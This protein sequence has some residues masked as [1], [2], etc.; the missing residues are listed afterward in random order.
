MRAITVD[1]SVFVSAARA[2][3]PSHADSLAF[4]DGLRESNNRLFLPTLALAEVAAAL[5]RTGTA[6]E[7]AQRY[8]LAI[9]K[10]PNVTLIALDEPLAREAAE[11]GA[12][13]KLRGADSVYIATARLVAAE[14]VTLD[15]EQLG[16]SLSILV[17]KKP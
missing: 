5:S 12:K 14:L 7:L 9:A 16:R 15:K 2:D 13:F 11:L 10:L 1:A 4:L 17:A 8:A 6:P 3:E